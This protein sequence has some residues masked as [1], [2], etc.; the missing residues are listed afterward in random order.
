MESIELQISNLDNFLTQ[1]NLADKSHISFAKF[2]NDAEMFCENKKDGVADKNLERYRKI[3]FDLE[4]INALALDDW[5]SAGRPENWLS[6]WE[7]KYR[8]NAQEVISE[9]RSLLLQ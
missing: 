4:I 3:W 9:L 7:A 5:D 1:A 8:S 2:V 6:Q